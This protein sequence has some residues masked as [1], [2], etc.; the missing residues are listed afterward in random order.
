MKEVKDRVLASILNAKAFTGCDLQ[1]SSGSSG[2]NNNNAKEDFSLSVEMDNDSD[3]DGRRSLQIAK[4]IVMKEL[5]H[6]IILNS[7]SLDLQTL[8]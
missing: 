5:E 4:Y 6:L 1:K 8:L 7:H 2:D 3:E